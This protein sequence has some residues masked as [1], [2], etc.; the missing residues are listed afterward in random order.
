MRISLL[1]FF[2]FIQSVSAAVPVLK[3]VQASRVDDVFVTEIQFDGDLESEDCSIDFINET[4]QVNVPGA[5]VA[6]KKRFDKVDD[7]EVKGIY[8]YQ[9]GPNTVRHRIILK[10][11][12]SAMKYENKVSLTLSG[13]NLVIKMGT[14]TP[15]ETAIGSILQELPP[16]SKND[17]NTKEAIA[18]PVEKLVMGGA[19]NAVI[20]ESALFAAASSAKNPVQIENSAPVKKIEPSEAEIPVLIANKPQASGSSAYWRLMMSFIIVALAGCAAFFGIKSYRHKGLAKNPQTN[21]R[22]MTQHYLGPKK[23]LAIIQVAGES[24]LV[25]ITEQS[26]T[27]IKTLSLL[28]EELPEISGKSFSDSLSQ[29]A[30]TKDV[31]EEFAIKGLKELVSARLHGMR[32]I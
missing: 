21:I 12:M 14:K 7:K 4:V 23:S 25:G 6:D 15:S 27:H 28:D 3:N 2:A 11:G 22:V 29:I 20:D 16:K 17:L 26:I 13:N 8:T 1:T 10:D 18:D 9:S 30:G 5:S 31:G 32:E 19:A 24:I